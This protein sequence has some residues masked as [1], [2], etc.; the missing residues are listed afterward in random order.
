MDFYLGLTQSA[1]TQMICAV[2]IAAATAVACG[3]ASSGGVFKMLI[4]HVPEP[5]ADHERRNRADLIEAICCQSGSR[6]SGSFPIGKAIS[7]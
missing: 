1:A 4:V 3:S 2:I 5:I 7:A 6:S